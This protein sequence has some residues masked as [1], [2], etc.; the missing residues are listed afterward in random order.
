VVTRYERALS[1]ADPE[2]EGAVEG[3]G[4]DLITLIPSVVRAVLVEVKN[5]SEALDVVE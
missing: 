5:E 4:W 3:L 1:L 2:N